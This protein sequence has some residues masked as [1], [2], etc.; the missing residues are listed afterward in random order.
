MAKGGK[1]KKKSSDVPEGAKV[2]ATNRKARFDYFIDETLEAGLVLKGTEVKSLRAGGVQFKDCYARIKNHEAFLIGMHIPPYTHA[3]ESMQHQT[4]RERKLLLHKREIE[5]LIA[6]IREKGFTLIP[7]AMYFKN[8]RAKVCIGLAKG[9]R[10]YDK[11]ETIRNRDRRR[12]E[13]RG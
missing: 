9:K 13:E 10:Q 5:R 11:R 7:L 4:E 2:V 8:G 3:G 6:K 1:K 12:D